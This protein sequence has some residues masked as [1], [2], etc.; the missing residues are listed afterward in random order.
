[1]KISE[2]EI[3]YI[4]YIAKSVAK[5]SQMEED[6]LLSEGVIRWMEIRQKKDIDVSSVEKYRAYLYSALY[7]YLVRVS[8]SD[9]LIHVPSYILENECYKDRYKDYKYIPVESVEIPVKAP[10]D[11]VERGNDTKAVIVKMLSSLK[12]REREIIKLRYGFYDE[13][14]MTLEEI[15]KKFGVGRERI[16]QIE[17]KAMRKLKICRFRHRNDLDALR[18]CYEVL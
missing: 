15:S 6:E 7:S 17:A 11:D 3:R 18:E 1:M 8:K 2:E 14:E 13:K 10:Y 12:D 16:R 9:N 4:R 5:I